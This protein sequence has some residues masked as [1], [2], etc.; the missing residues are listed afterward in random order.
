VI[1]WFC[2]EGTRSVHWHELTA[3]ACLKCGGKFIPGASPAG[4]CPACLLATA[5]SSDLDIEGSE[6]PSTTLPPGT[7]VGPFQLVGV[8]GKGGMATVYEAYDGRLERAIALKVLPP[9]FLHDETFARRFEK[10]ARVVA[11]LEHPNI[12]PIY[13]SGV[14]EGIP[15]MSMR[16]LAGGSVGRLLKNHR[17]DTGQVVRILR[18]IANALDYAHA[19]GVVHR[20]IKPTNLLLDG[21]GQVCVGDF[22]LAQ[23]MERGPGLTRS[24]TLAGTPQYMAP[25]QALGNPADHRCDIYSLGI[26]AFE[27][28]VGD[29]PFTADSPVAVLLKHVNEPLPEP[30]AERLAPALMQA[31]QKAT[32]K[33][34][35]DR[36]PSAGAFVAALEGAGAA[37]PGNPETRDVTGAERPRRSKIGR[38]GAAGAATLAAAGLAWFVLQGR[39]LPQ[40][41]PAIA[42]E[43]ATDTALPAPPASGSQEVNAVSAAS[44]TAPNRQSAR[45]P[46]A[47]RPPTQEMPAPSIESAP[48]LPTAAVNIESPPTPLEQLNPDI[49]AA[50][51]TVGPEADSAPPQAP[52]VADV[53]TPPIRTRMVSPDYPSVARAAEL[54]GDVVLRAIVGPDG[55]V[56]DVEVLQA[57]HP[58][59]DEA[60][61]KAVLRYE[62]RPGRRNGIAESAIVR[63]TV[64][65]RLR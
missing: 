40:S 27:M 32:A 59:L 29:V 33:D 56:R 2:H 52:V 6:Y 22:G 14:D 50:T 9:E 17:P 13:A 25:E 62:Y 36:W 30:P 60:A 3:S 58:V 42:S 23:M 35:G 19:R 55:R 5:L 54:E 38:L 21:S 48:P 53:V 8:L 26:V 31:I 46:P 63:I 47:E 20:D 51:D 4:L 24:G 18:D 37:R 1:G 49:P 44:P 45:T 12:V 34:P 7:T 28:F 11:K 61:R 39:P 43:P 15:W 10:E 65:F 41:P 16:L 57:V 64:S